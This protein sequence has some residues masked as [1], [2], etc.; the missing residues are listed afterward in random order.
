MPAILYHRRNELTADTPTTHSGSGH[1][2]VDRGDSITTAVEANVPD[3]IA[4]IS[5]YY[6]LPTSKRVYERLLRMEADLVAVSVRERLDGGQERASVRFIHD[7]RTHRTSHPQALRGEESNCGR[8]RP[9]P[10]K[11]R[12]RLA[13]VA[14]RT[15]SRPMLTITGDTLNTN[16]AAQFSAVFGNK[17]HR[18]H[19]DRRPCSPKSAWSDLLPPTFGVGQTAAAE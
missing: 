17:H 5:Y 13:C 2:F 10:M 12:F 9:A 19:I 18:R 14:L 11:G 3:N 6:K 1:N 7:R 4:D 8:S 16:G 15:T